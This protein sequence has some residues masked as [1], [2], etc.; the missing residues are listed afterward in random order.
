MIKTRIQ[1][2]QQSLESK[3]ALLVTSEANRFYL[4]GFE[5]SAGSVL[6]T[7]DAAYFLIDF[8]YVEKAKKVVD[9]CTVQLSNRSNEEIKDLLIKH[10]I[11]R[12]YLETY[13]VSMS[14][15]I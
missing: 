14:A 4:T 8:R 13:S 9:S 11:T 15:I 10:G 7:K 6:V 1:T 12:L 3:E 5:S 2:I